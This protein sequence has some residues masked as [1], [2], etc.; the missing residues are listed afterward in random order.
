[1]TDFVLIGKVR[2]YIT[3][4]DITAAPDDVLVEG[5][6][7][8]IINDQEKVSIRKGYSLVG[9]ANTATTPIESSVDWENSSGDI[10]FLRGYDDELE[11]YVGPINSIEFDSWEKLKDG[12]ADVDFQFAAVWNSTEKIDL[13]LAVVGDDNLYEWSGG[14]TTFASLT[15]NTIT[16]QGTGTWA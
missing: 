8:T 2:G 3:K 5:S 16:K 7:N 15:S 13:L 12:W 9:A 6:Q 1:M 4:P 10:L 11:V 14:I